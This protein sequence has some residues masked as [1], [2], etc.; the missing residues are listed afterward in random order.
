MAEGTMESSSSCFPY[1]GVDIFFL[2][3]RL[4]ALIEQKKALL[5]ESTLSLPILLFY[6]LKI[7]PG[8]CFAFLLFSALFVLLLKDY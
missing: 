4:V 7:T 3:H 1:N 8:F 5:T 6:F 2:L